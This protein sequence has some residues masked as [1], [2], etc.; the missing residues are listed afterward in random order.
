MIHEVHVNGNKV[1]ESSSGIANNRSKYVSNYNGGVFLLR[2][3][4][5]ISIRIPIAK[6]YLMDPAA[7]YLGAFLLYPTEKWKRR[8]TKGFLSVAISR[9]LSFA[10]NLCRTPKEELEREEVGQAG[11]VAP[12]RMRLKGFGLHMP[13]ISAFKFFEPIWIAW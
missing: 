8:K 11:T 3:L 10:P 4:D 2:S 7:S 1:L 6:L 12:L 13:E 5:K 9:P